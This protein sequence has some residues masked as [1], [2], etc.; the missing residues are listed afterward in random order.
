MLVIC[1]THVLIWQLRF[2]TKQCIFAFGKVYRLPKFIALLSLKMLEICN[3]VGRIRTNWTICDQNKISFLK[4]LYFRLS[5][6]SIPTN[7]PNNLPKIYFYFT[8]TI[9]TQEILS[10]L[11]A[12]NKNVC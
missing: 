9:T 3:R 11:V 5:I 10:S 4:I 8:L 2:L 1:S 6:S 12:Y 7:C